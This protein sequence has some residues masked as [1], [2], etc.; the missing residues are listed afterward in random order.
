MNKQL[1]ISFIDISTALFYRQ[2]VQLGSHFSG[3]Q[4][5]ENK[6]GFYELPVVYPDRSIFQFFF[7]L[8]VIGF[9][10]CFEPFIDRFSPPFQQSAERCHDTDSLHAGRCRQ[11]DDL[12]RNLP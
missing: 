1:S 6:F 9:S 7:E 4:L 11:P 12:R 3:R 5:F 2:S 8:F 10:S